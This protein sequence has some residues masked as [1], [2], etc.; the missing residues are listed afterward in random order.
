MTMNCPEFR[1]LAGAQPHSTAPEILAHAAQC[2]ACARYLSEM[3][4][5]DQLIHRALSIDVP[6]QAMAPASADVLPF[7][8]P[9]KAAPRRPRTYRWSMAAS[10]LVAVAATVVWVGYPRESLAADAVDHALHEPESLTRTSTMV[11]EQELQEVLA[12]AHVRLKPGMSNVS[13][14]SFCPFRGHHVP[15]F[16]V[17]TTAGP[18]TVLLLRD[19]KPVTRSKD[20]VEGKFQG[21]IVPAPQGVLAVLGEHVPVNEV[22]AQ[23][24]A[25]VEYEPS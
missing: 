15:H 5:M 2:E 22:A 6:E 25:A 1:R 10:L 9:P 4:Q 8:A 23:V 18:V 11:S 14:A 17:Q 7:Q 13:Y 12:H 24:L 19:E 20:F 16:V 21:V 3:Q